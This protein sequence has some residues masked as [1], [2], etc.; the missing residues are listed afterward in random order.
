MNLLVF[1]ISGMTFVERIASQR[2]LYDAAVPASLDVQQARLE[3][4]SRDA[5]EWRTV[6]SVCG[7]NRGLA[8][9]LGLDVIEARVDAAVEDREA[10]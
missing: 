10:A 2:D 8:A 4:V 5:R 3:P 1:L 9:L 6:C 7:D